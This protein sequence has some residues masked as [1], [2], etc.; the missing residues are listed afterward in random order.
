[1]DFSERYFFRRSLSPKRNKGELFD[2]IGGDAFK[3]RMAR[4]R[5]S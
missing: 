5:W 4:P 1:M 3:E 2:R